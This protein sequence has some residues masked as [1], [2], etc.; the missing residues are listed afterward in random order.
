MNNNIF[1]REI[2]E[3]QSKYKLI[4]K[5]VTQQSSYN[6]S[7]E[8]EDYLYNNGALKKITILDKENDGNIYYTLNDDVKLSL[9][10]GII[11]IIG[12]QY[13]NVIAS[14]ILVHTTNNNKFQIRRNDHNN[15]NLSLNWFRE[16]YD[17]NFEGA[18]FCVEYDKNKKILKINNT[19]SNS[20]LV[21]K[22]KIEDEGNK[23]NEYINMFKTYYLNNLNSLKT[24]EELYIQTRKKFIEEYPIE[25]FKNLT[26]DEYCLGSDNF[27]DSFCYKLEFGKYKYAAAGIGGKN[28]SKFGIYKSRQTHGY[29]YDKQNVENIDEFWQSFRKELY[30]FLKE[31]ETSI[32]P[33]SIS[34]KY[35]LLKGMNLVLTKLLCI[36]YPNK[37]INICKKSSLELLLRYFG[38]SY[39]K[40]MQNDELSFIL[41]KMIRKD[42]D[43]LN[44]NDSWYIGDALWHFIKDIIETSEIEENIDS[45]IITEKYT[46]EKFLEE[47]FMSELEYS[48]LVNL[49]KYKK[50]IILQG[51]PGVGKTFMARR[52]AYSI[53]GN[54]SNDQ[55]LSIQF[56]QSYSYEDFI[57]GIRPNDK[58][59]FNLVDGVFK[60]FVNL[61]K[62]NRDKQYFCIIDEINRGNLSKILGELMK[63]IESDKR[64]IEN[65]ILPYS[66]ENFI[67]PSNL[68][69]IG[70]M[71]TADR[72]L[73]MVDYA[74]RRRF[75]F[76]LVKPA[77]NK[78]E[79]KDYLINVNG[80]SDKHV[81]YICNKFININ[82]LIS[83]D[84]GQGFEI[85]HSYFVD[86]LNEDDFDSLYSLIVEYELKPLLE[87]YWY[88]DEN[89]VYEYKNM[90]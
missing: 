37:F 15:D 35:P 70:T 33:I 19:I 73:S 40:N 50:N 2:S 87:E 76:Y 1:I 82:D 29:I 4:K 34:E 46:K 90:L 52:L 45:N 41:N 13:K 27:E 47:V 21:S 20:K 83:K 77:F 85:G 53:I 18:N 36:Y 5:N 48:N 38:Y 8:L 89:K 71:N 6:L 57:E 81:I 17:K 79:F 39:D 59:E 86:S 69:I 51:S 24:N 31:Y 56:H 44:K 3:T 54:K 16:L 67:V 28:A 32:E 43:I 65:V 84:L 63:L 12:N 42:I 14:I 23:T 88:D 64:D 60:D 22:A 9:G 26:I 78:K 62:K 25:K 58:G 11:N 30:N 72:S 66:K 74:L 55:I 68:Y 61:A 10:E 75:A 7:V 80:L 49:L